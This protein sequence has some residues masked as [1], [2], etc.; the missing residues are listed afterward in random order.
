MANRKTP[1]AIVKVDPAARSF[2]SAACGWCTLL[3]DA[4]NDA[5]IR[6]AGFN[7]FLTA[8]NKSPQEAFETLCDW[9][10]DGTWF[11]IESHPEIADADGVPGLDLLITAQDSSPDF[12]PWLFAGTQYLDLPSG[13][14]TIAYEQEFF[15]S[16]YLDEFPTFDA[17]NPEV[18]SFSNR[19]FCDATS[20]R[21]T[22][23]PGLYVCRAYTRDLTNG[24]SSD[25]RHADLIV[26][27][28]PVARPK[29]FPSV[30]PLM[31]HKKA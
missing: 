28:D 7:P 26:T 19:D 24:T 11:A 12:G 27:M 22:M 31:P 29:S 16:W 8:R 9:A 4:V 2:R 18:E 5:S 23:D 10:K 6:N 3:F 15:D 30:D 20:Y 1:P 14:L 13:V 17:T 21:I 25:G